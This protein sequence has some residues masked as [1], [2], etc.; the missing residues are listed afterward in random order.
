MTH[1]TSTPNTVNSGISNTQDSSAA[2][3]TD[4]AQRTIT[5]RAIDAGIWGVPILSFHAMRE[6]YFRDAGAQYNDIVYWSKFA[7]W[8][9]QTTTPNSSSYYV[10]LHFNTSNGP[11]V[12][13]IPEAD[14]ANIFGTIV[15]AWQH[16]LGEFG[17]AVAGDGGKAQKFLILPPD[18]EGD[19]PEGYTVLKYNTYNGFSLIRSIP[20][21]LSEEAVAGAIAL[22]KRLRVYPLADAANPP[23]QRYIDMAD[24]LYDGIVYWDASVY[25]NLSEMINEEPVLEQDRAVMGLWVPVG[26]KKDQEFAPD[27]ETRQILERSAREVHEWLKEN[28]VT[29]KTPVWSTK[30]SW[31]LPAGPA[32]PETLLTWQYPDYLDV[33]SRALGLFS[34]F[35][36]P[37]TLGAGTYYFGTFVDADGNRLRGE[38]SYRLHVPANPPARQYWALTLYDTETCGFIRDMPHTGLDSFNKNLKQNE[39]GSW[40]L[41][42][43][44][45]APAGKES[46]WIPTAEG[47]MWFPYFRLFGPDPAF[48][49]NSD[50]W[51]IHEF[52]HLKN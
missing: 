11:I 36:P 7:D 43:G 12:L 30:T 34:F 51:K 9:Y 50:T 2:L 29:F 41:Y 46:N 17:S 26:L 45:K 16:P 13:D 48:I 33:D 22:V 42:I 23:Q 27:A 19:I 40:D 25:A 32:G 31:T 49:Q 8:K 24:K 38:E 14:T 6:A 1:Q 10:Y 20:F 44:P 4:L 28:L 39:D 52:E 5:R 37:K 47:R 18:F 35:S 15:N 21:E 3:R